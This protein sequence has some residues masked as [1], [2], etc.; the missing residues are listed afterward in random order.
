MSLLMQALKKAERAKQNQLVEEEPAK[1]SEEL[2][3]ALSLAPQEPLA[4]SHAGARPDLSLESYDNPALSLSPLPEET[5]VA[6]APAAAPELLEPTLSAEPPVAPAP[7]ADPVPP[8]RAAAAASR[9]AANAATAAAGAAHAASVAADAAAAG[10]RPS[11]RPARNAAASPRPSS[12]PPSRVGR[13]A[14]ARQPRSIDAQTLRL[15]VLVGIVVLIVAVFGYLYWQ[16]VSAPGAGARLPMVP[17]PP[18]TA[19]SAVDNS[20]LIVAAPSAGAPVTAAAGA[21]EPQAP[22][23]GGLP[24]AATQAAAGQI[25]PLQPAAMPQERATTPPAGAPSSRLSPEAIAAMARFGAPQ[26]PAR[27]TVGPGSAQE[28]A[29]QRAL[30]ASDPNLHAYAP[31]GAPA[32]AGQ[33]A[34]MPPPGAAQ[35]YAPPAMQ[36]QPMSSPSTVVDNG[37][38]RLQRSDRGAGV[39][40]ALQAA[41]AAFNAGDLAGARQ[42]YLTVQRSDPNN[43]DVLLGLA[44]IALRENQPGQA[45]SNY[46]RLLELDPNDGEAVSGLIGLRHGDPAESEVRL[47]AILQR[48]PEAAPV[49]FAMGNLVAQQGRWSEAQQIYFRAYS[50]NPANADYAFNVAVGLDRLNQ[51]RLAITYYQRALAL[52]TN[53]PGSFDRTAARRRL[54]ELGSA[55][56]APAAQP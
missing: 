6:P 38:I 14:Q 30:A 27:P 18:P 3:Q 13:A 56:A 50:A 10:A 22:V 12:A 35:A 24:S 53:N 8:A 34:G 5:A 17:M 48:S 36:G 55:V 19:A 9:A 47:K 21:S 52:S 40:P 23:Q 32:G 54:H 44:A 26:A 41:Y 11:P 28:A 7:P 20:G 1:P 29:R 15:G 31:P 37:D 16:A 42:Y 25:T 33:V 39:N 51:P 46:L 2:D 4:P 43:R 49:L 45:A